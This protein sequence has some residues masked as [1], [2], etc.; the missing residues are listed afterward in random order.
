LPADFILILVLTLVLTKLRPK[1][2]QI[3]S[4]LWS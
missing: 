4:W 1:T 2:G 3:R